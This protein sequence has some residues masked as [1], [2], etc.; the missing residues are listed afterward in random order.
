M[1]HKIPRL[2]LIGISNGGKTTRGDKRIG[3]PCLRKGDVVS[4]PCR[5]TY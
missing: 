5:M 2:E 1:G 3:L 4:L